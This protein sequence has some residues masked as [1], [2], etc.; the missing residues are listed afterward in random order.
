MSDLL[1]PALIIGGA[2]LATL[3]LGRFAKAND[4]PSK[5]DD[6][7]S[8]KAVLWNT[9]VSIP[10]LD[11]TQRYFL[12]LVAERESHY[13]TSAHNDSAWEVAAS[14]K[15]L[16][17]NP[18]LR[19]RLERCSG[20]WGIGSGGYFGRLLPYFGSDMLFIF[21]DDCSHVQPHLVFERRHAIVS[22]LNTARRLQNY[23]AFQAN[24]TVGTLRLGWASPGLM[25][26]PQDQSRLRKYREDAARAK[27]PNGIVGATIRRFP[28]DLRGIF[29]RMQ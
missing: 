20:G 5:D 14:V 6:G 8:N 13:H 28:E 7:V 23:P 29:N 21:G 9:L 12:I 3:A 27:L 26:V 1:T 25:K 2:L 10:E 17:N 4:L 16:E 22:A 15:A 11:N 18:D 19:S 24:P